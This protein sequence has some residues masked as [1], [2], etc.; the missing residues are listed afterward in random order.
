[1]KLYHIII[2]SL[3]TYLCEG[4]ILWRYCSLLFVRKYS[5]KKCC[6]IYFVLYSIS[7]IFSVLSI[8]AINSILFFLNTMLIIKLTYKVTWGKSLFHAI[9]AT[10]MMIIT[11]ML[12]TVIWFI[13]LFTI[14]NFRF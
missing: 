3:I 6:V 2:L 5:V 10:F 9:I 1:M 4:Y 7:V 11:E 8:P 14:F 12:I 13:I